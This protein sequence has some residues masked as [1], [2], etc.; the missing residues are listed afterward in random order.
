MRLPDRDRVVW[1]DSICINQEDTDERNYQVALMCTIYS[2]AVEC[3]VWIGE[4]DDGSVE[5]TFASLRELYIE[6]R[7]VTA[8]F[9]TFKQTV[10]PGWW[11]VYGEPSQVKFDP[12][13][14]AQLFYRP[15]FARLWYVCS[16]VAPG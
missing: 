5:A 15:W 4:D 13:A 9:E 11:S 12:Q 3:L 1:I 8:D 16:D 7:R 14:M 2:G 6:A 10:W